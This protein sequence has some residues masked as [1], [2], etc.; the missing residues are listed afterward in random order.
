MF[1]ILQVLLPP[2][3]ISSLA[4]PFSERCSGKQTDPAFQ[5]F[6][7]VVP[8]V[9]SIDVFLSGSRVSNSV[10]LVLYHTHTYLKPGSHLLETAV[11][12]LLGIEMINNHPGELL[13]LEPRC[14]ERKAPT[15]EITCRALVLK[16][17]LHN[18]VLYNTRQDST[19]RCTVGRDL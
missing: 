3:S 7:G 5:L 2:W 16:S 9:L 8:D 17:G 10:R 14:N 18:K 11:F 15:P 13:L 4:P 19:G 1:S 12:V 6:W